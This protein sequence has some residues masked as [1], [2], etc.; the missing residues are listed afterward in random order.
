MG[1]EGSVVEVGTYLFEPAMKELNY[2]GLAIADEVVDGGGATLAVFNRS[3]EPVI[4]EEGQVLGEL[5]EAVVVK[6]GDLPQV[7]DLPVAA[8]LEGEDDGREQKVVEALG[9]SKVDELDLREME[10]LRELVVEFSD[11]FALSHLELGRTSIATHHIDTGDSAAV[12][13][14]PRRIPFA[15][16]SKV[17]KLVE[18]MLNQGVIKP[19]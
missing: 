1:L 11:L 3:E 2:K 14:P 4:L 9:I 8:V 5:Q 6:K 19:D 7:S 12:R 13:Q 17:E 16:H 15:L 10:Q 18:E